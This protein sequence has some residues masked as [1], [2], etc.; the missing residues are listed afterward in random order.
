MRTDRTDDLAEPATPGFDPE[1]ARDL[2]E[3]IAALSQ[4]A[5][6]RRRPLTPSA[7][8][9]ARRPVRPER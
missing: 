6:P 2:V 4:P 8:P 3:L 9:V 7:D 5:P 1:A